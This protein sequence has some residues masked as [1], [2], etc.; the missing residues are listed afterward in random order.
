MCGHWELWKVAQLAIFCTIW[1]PCTLLYCRSFPN[2]WPKHILFYASL[3]CSLRSWLSI[4]SCLTFDCNHGP[5][6]R[7][8]LPLS[9]SNGVWYYHKLDGKRA[10][11]AST[12]HVVSMFLQLWLVS[13]SALRNWRSAPPYGLHLFCRLMCFV[14]VHGPS[15]KCVG[16][17]MALLWCLAVEFMWD[18]VVESLEQLTDDDNTVPRGCILA[19][20]MGLGKTLSVCSTND[21]YRLICK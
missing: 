3:T 6:V 10:H 11:C 1:Q 18:N 13:G 19:H 2:P 8:H 17:C 15:A 5:I 12:S 14:V 16:I 20:C 21:C 7:T 4:P 9:P